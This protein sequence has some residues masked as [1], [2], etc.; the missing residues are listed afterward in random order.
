MIFTDYWITV[1]LKIWEMWNTVFF[2]ANKLIERWYLLG[3]FE[4][5]MIYEDL[6][7]IVFCAVEWIWHE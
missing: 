7:N 3:I 1:I 6:G 5:S 4:F 2:G